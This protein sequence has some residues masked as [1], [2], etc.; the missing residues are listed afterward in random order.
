MQHWV[1]ALEQ[2]SLNEVIQGSWAKF[3][4]SLSRQSVFEDLVT[5]HNDFLDAV[6]RQTVDI[7]S[8]N[9]LIQIVLDVIYK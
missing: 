9:K 7:I 2:Y 6:K 4:Q 1:T 8:L 5:L 3:K